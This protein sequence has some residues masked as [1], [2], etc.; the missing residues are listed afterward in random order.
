[1]DFIEQVKKS[2]DIVRTIGE[3]TLLEQVAGNRY[4]GPCPF[5]QGKAPSFT[6]W[7]DIQTYKC[8]GCEEAGDVFKFIM[9]IES[10][11]FMG[12]L[13]LLAGRYGITVPSH[14]PKV[15]S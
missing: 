3:Y 7:S 9:K 8:F 12:A 14:E 1:M 13:K 2:A 5:H 10:T 6:V 4:L 11:D 15:D